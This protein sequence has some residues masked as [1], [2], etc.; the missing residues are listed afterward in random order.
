MKVLLL[1]GSPNEK[2]CTY[3]ALKEVAD[4]LETEGILTEILWIGSEPVRD[5]MDCG[6]CGK[7][8]ACI[9]D[10]DGVNAFVEK[11]K[12]ADG[13]VFGT[14][15]YFSHP[16]GSLLSF[17]DRALYGC[18]DLF[19]HKPAAAVAS[20]RRAGNVASVDVLNKYFTLAQMPVVSSSYWNVVFGNTPEEVK[21]DLEGL[22]IMR[23]LGRNMAW[24]MKCIEAGRAQGILAPER[25]RAFVTNFIR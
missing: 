15:V 16:S 11:A 3:T 12:A 19:A 23:N 21:Q 25:E 6:S 5:C 4:T 18:R 13:F 9:F 20:A 17:M 22:Q 1:N 7:P 10:E 24:L 2:G 14:P 8:Q